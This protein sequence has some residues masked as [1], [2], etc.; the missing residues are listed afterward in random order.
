MHLL[1]SPAA[2]PHQHSACSDK[3]GAAG[4]HASF[5]V[6]EQTPRPAR[7]G[8]HVFGGGGGACKAGL[9]GWGCRWTSRYH[10]PS[11]GKRSKPSQGSVMSLEVRGCPHRTWGEFRHKTISNVHGRHGLVLSLSG[12]ALLLLFSPPAAPHAMQNVAPVY[13]CHHATNPSS[14]WFKAV[15]QRPG[16]SHHPTIH[17]VCSKCMLQVLHGVSGVC[18]CQVCHTVPRGSRHVATA[19]VPATRS[20]ARMMGR[21]IC[22]TAR[23]AMG[24]VGS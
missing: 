14:S 21:G 3:P 2:A 20:G 15:H 18:R 22:G 17:S 19:R 8:V 16:P 6:E 10:T 1:F 4:A 9:W 12:A 23:G 13:H 7:A 24:V 11:V 5:P